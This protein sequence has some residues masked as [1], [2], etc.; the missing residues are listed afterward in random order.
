MN[1]TDL[2][3]SADY[4]E[5]L[6]PLDDGAPTRALSELWR[7][8]FLPDKQMQHPDTKRLRANA[9]LIA[10]LQAMDSTGLQRLIVHLEDLGHSGYE[11]VRLFARTG[12][13]AHLR[14][15]DYSTVIEALKQAPGA[16]GGSPGPNPPSDPLDFVSDV[17]SVEHDEADFLKQLAERS[18]DSSSS[19]N[20]VLTV[21]GTRVLWDS[22]NMESLARVL[23]DTSDPQGYA[24]SAGSIEH[25]PE[26]EPEPLPGKGIVKWQTLDVLLDNIRKLER[27]ATVRGTSEALERIVNL[28]SKLTEYADSIPREGIRLLLASKKL[29]SAVKNL[30]TTGYSS[31]K[32]WRNCGRTSRQLTSDISPRLPNNLH[33]PT[34]E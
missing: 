10:Q 1:L 6:L 14:A 8:G 21:G 32:N 29:E 23:S 13:K 28:R 24:G 33:L 2:A 12:R 25:M 20:D 15:L 16:P 22:V 19:E 18:S 9:D 4:C 7:L 11:A 31:G 34:S 26:N 30:S 27:R 17:T 5:S 3:A